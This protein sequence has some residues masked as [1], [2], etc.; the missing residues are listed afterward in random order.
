MEVIVATS[1]TSLITVITLCCL[2][3][4]CLTPLQVNLFFSCMWAISF[5]LLS[6]ISRISSSVKKIATPTLALMPAEEAGATFRDQQAQPRSARRDWW[7]CPVLPPLCQVLGV[8][9]LVS[10]QLDSSGQVNAISL[11]PV[12]LYKR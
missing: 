9:A 3:F 6:V 1:L 8:A 2:F 5:L 11:S 4:M 12:L 10:L 7:H